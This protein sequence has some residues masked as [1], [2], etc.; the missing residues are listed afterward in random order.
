LLVGLRK[1]NK[2]MLTIVQLLFLTTTPGD[3]GERGD[4]GVPGFATKG[5]K[6]EHGSP[7]PRGSQGI[8]GPGKYFKK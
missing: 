6:G 1:N 2:I 8:Q 7:G 3:K 4:I 5:D